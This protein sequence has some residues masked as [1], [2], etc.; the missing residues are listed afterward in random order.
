MNATFPISLSVCEIEK[1]LRR[2]QN[3]NGKTDCSL[4]IKLFTAKGDRLRMKP[5]KR[6]HW[7]CIFLTK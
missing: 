4:A 6:T 2:K 3:L 1:G 7:C 5:L